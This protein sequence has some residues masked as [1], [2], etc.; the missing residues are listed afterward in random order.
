MNEH[1]LITLTTDFGDGSPYVAQ[2]KGVLTDRVPDAILVDVTHAIPPQDVTAGAL[3]IAD[4]TPWFP[5]RTVHVGVVDPGVGTGR[6]ILAGRLAR[7][8]FVGPDNGLFSLAEIRQ[9]VVLE[10]RDHW[11]ANVTATFHGRDMMAPVAAAL[12]AGVPLEEL[13]PATTEWARLSLPPPIVSGNRVNGKVIHV[14]RFGN[15]ITNL[16]RED[17][18]ADPDAADPDVIVEDRPVRFVRCYGEADPGDLVAL[19]GSSGRLEIAVV[20]GSGADTLGRDPAVSAAAATIP[21]K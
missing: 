7:G 3:V 12:A 20:N 17:V 1:P 21:P 14:D 15:L 18:A 8:W 19:I 16:G 4:T 6:R 13:G 11:L 2:M 10:N 5:E 9:S